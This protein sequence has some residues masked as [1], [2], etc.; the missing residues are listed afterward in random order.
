M[1]C[2]ARVQ[3][4]AD[5]DACLDALPSRVPA[6]PAAEEL[7]AVEEPGPGDTPSPRWHLRYPPQP[8]APAVVAPPLVVE[9]LARYRRC[10]GPGK[11]LEAWRVAEAVAAWLP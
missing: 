5:L 1:R 9:A 7:H 2:H 3:A 11:V 4:D 6:I 10:V 8:P